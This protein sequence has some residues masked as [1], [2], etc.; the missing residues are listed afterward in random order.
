M[1]Y[2]VVVDDLELYFRFSFSPAKLSSIT[3]E[4][5]NSTKITFAGL[6]F[7][8]VFCNIIFV[9]VHS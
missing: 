1:A 7:N 5:D 9:F 6:S 2:V 4:L 3:K 8:L